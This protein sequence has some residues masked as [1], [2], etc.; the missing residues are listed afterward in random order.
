MSHDNRIFRAETGNKGNLKS[1]LFGE[2]GQ[3]RLESKN[4]TELLN[5]T[6]DLVIPSAEVEPQ[7]REELGAKRAC[8]FP[9][10]KE[11]FYTDMRGNICI[12]KVNFE[13]NELLAEIDFVKVLETREPIE[14]EL[15]RLGYEIISGTRFIGVVQVQIDNYNKRKS[16]TK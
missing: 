13:K 14:K 9:N 1:S 3:D 5:P 7:F 10:G 2:F 4:A 12:A 15:K 6:N 11:I 8:Y 16:G